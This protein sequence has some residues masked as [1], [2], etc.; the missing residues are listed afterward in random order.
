MSAVAS[1]RMPGVLPI[2]NP[3]GGGIGNGDVV[4]PDSMI[5][6]N[7]LWTDDIHVSP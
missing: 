2:R 7:I 5:A 1:V 4:K 6:D 3:S